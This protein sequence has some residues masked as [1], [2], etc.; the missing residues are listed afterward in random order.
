M[1]ALI[2][3]GGKWKVSKSLSP[4][5]YF[6]MRER[7]C[8]RPRRGGGC[9]KIFSRLLKSDTVENGSASSTGA[10]MWFAP[11]LTAAYAL[12]L[13]FAMFHHEMYRDEFQAWMI[14]RDST[15]ILDLLHNLKY[16][17]H[18][19]LWHLLLMPLTRLTS[20]PVAMQ[21]L[22]F[23]IASTTVF[24]VA[25]YAPFSPLQKVLFA[26]GYYPLYR[27]AVISRSYALVLLLVVTLCVWLK[28]RWQKPLR[29]ALVLVLLSHTT[30]HAC[31]LAIGVVIGLMLDYL[32][33]RRSLVQDKAVSRWKIYAAFS[34]VVAGILAAVLQMSPP[35]DSHFYSPWHWTPEISRIKWLV[36]ESFNPL[37]PTP[38]GMRLS[39]LIHSVMGPNVIFVMIG[40]LLAAVI[41]YYR[42][43][44]AALVMFFSCVSGLAVFF[45]AKYFNG[46]HHS[47]FYL[48]AFLLLVWGGRHMTAAAAKSRSRLSAV[49]NTCAG[50]LMTGFLLLQVISGFKFVAYDVKHPFTLAHRTAEYI[51]DNNLDSLPMIGVA[52][53][54]ASTV[55][56]Y[57]GADSRIDYVRE[58]RGKSFIVWDNTW[59]RNNI[60]DAAAIAHAEKVA[61]QT[62]GKVLL[63]FNRQLELKPDERRFVQP[64]AAFTGA[65]PIRDE[66]FY[67]YFYESPADGTVRR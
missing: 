24:V 2:K 21:G 38:E 66:N 6:Q 19:A 40:A 49:G 37:F 11:V 53:Y 5:T 51:R 35:A 47:G 3:Q 15:G 54:A 65:R 25:K 59:G 41:A 9:C 60:S 39:D 43:C 17:G 57:L 26:F 18:P 62:G 55:A 46:L 23:L 42:N 32:L 61:A 4:S 34:I 29:V 22:H 67:L 44:P 45:Y 28:Q 10:G 58:N 31:I 27:Y 33:R 30:V 48:L 7:I 20:D 1:Q 63:I 50:H 14:A 52:D 56:G 16:E 36:I 13:S 64:I 8:T 12:V